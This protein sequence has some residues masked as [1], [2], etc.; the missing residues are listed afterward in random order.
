M[1]TELSKTTIPLT[2][3]KVEDRRSIWNILLLTLAP[4][5][6]PAIIGAV[7][8]ACTMLNRDLIDPTNFLLQQK[9]FAIILIAG[10]V[11]AMIV[12]TVSVKY[13]LRKIRMWRQSAYTRQVNEGLIALTVVTSMMVLPV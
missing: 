13:A 6:L 10:L 8:L 9:N 3:T 1:N 7:V 5:Y 12:Y 4:L 2:G 11:S